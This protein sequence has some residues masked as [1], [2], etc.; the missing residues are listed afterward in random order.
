MKKLLPLLV[1]LVGCAPLSQAPLVYNSKVIFGGRISA[2][3]PQ[4]PGVDI[5]V[6]LTTEDSAFIPV[7]VAKLPKK[8]GGDDGSSDIKLIKGTYAGSINPATIE[9]AA[10]T[11]HAAETMFIEKSAALI[12]V[13]K[14][15]DANKAQIA[16]YGELKQ[17]QD[18]LKS[19]IST[20]DPNSSE[21]GTKQASLQAI[22]NQLQSLPTSDETL[23]INTELAQAQAE[24]DSAETNVKKAT[25]ELEK[26]EGKTDAY[27]VF[28]SFDSKNSVAGSANAGISLGKM[29]STGVAAQNISQG[30]QQS[31][32]YLAVKECLDSLRAVVSS[33]VTPEIAEK[34]CGKQ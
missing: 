11:L 34:I 13:Q 21:F 8:F 30:I 1:S 24:K 27:S 16:K 9:A 15:I 2:T 33:T 4:T 6:G 22:I 5:N 20:L 25:A 17:Q 3:N 31:H 29:F 23:R 12:E 28:G 14:K 26:V 19:E 10:D 7:A 18:L 32:N